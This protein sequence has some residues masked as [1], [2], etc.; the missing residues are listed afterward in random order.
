MNKYSA[1]VYAIVGEVPA[2]K[3]TTYGAIGK[4]T[5]AHPRLVGQ[6]LHRNP[7]PSAVPCHRVVR[8]DGRIA[9]G[10]AFGGQVAQAE[11]LTREGLHIKNNRIT[12]SS[13]VMF[14][15]FDR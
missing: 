15:L 14:N 9:T 8:S 13:E 11:R 2:G 12:L 6:I 4:L 3:V 1:E 7:N 10:Y 5:G